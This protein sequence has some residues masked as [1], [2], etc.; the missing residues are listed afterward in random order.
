M[1]RIIVKEDNIIKQKLNNKIELT[2]KEKSDFFTVNTITLD[3]I[4]DTELHIEYDTTKDIKLDIIIN[5]HDNVKTKIQ[6]FRTGTNHKIRYNYNLGENAKLKLLKFYDT[7]AIKEYAVINLNGK[8]STIFY[9]LKT[10]CTYYQKY[11]I[12]IKHNNHNTKSIIKNHGINIEK[13]NLIFNISSFLEKGNKNCILKQQNIINNKTDN[14]VIIVPNS[15]IDEADAVVETKAQVG[16]FDCQSL[17][18]EGMNKYL[19]DKINEAIIKY[20]R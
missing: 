15:F 8:N 17:L 7:R 13:G 5:I 9:T 20:W 2:T 19:K 10:I 14:E 6:E 3:I 1:N 4:E 11:D 12:N 16:N 18:Q